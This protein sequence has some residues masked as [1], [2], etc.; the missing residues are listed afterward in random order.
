MGKQR[1]TNLLEERSYNTY[2]KKGGILNCSNWRGITPLSVPGKVLASIILDTSSDNS[3][4]GS[5]E[6]RHVASRYSP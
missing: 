2:A 1:G 4:Q 3:K 6:D 5:D